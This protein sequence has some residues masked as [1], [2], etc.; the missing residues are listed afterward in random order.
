M[1]DS[2]HKVLRKTVETVIFPALCATLT[3]GASTFLHRFMFY[4]VYTVYTVFSVYVIYVLI[5]SG[6]RLFPNWSRTLLHRF[7]RFYTVSTVSTR[8]NLDKE[9]STFVKKR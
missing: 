8:K 2:T 1:Q 3:V 9:L 5:I 7:H 4:D 6:L